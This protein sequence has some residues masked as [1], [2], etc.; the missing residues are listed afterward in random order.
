MV[1][2]YN[3]QADRRDHRSPIDRTALAPVARA[4]ALLLIVSLVGSTRVAGQGSGEY[5]VKA[6]FL[7]NFAKFVDWPADAG[8]GTG[9][10]V[11]GILGDDPF[12]GTLDQV[13]AGKTVNGSRLA[14]TRLK[15]GQDLRRCH[16]LFIGASEHKRL[17]QIFQSLNGAGVLTVSDMEQFHQQGGMIRF[18]IEQSKVRFEINVAAAE[19]AGLKVSSKLLALAKSVIG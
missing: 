11:I 14:V 17:P 4:T 1:R 13:V 6:A 8:N 12:G 9:A 7:Y 10:I 3:N 2:D 19:K 5:S 15:F 16:I 18:V